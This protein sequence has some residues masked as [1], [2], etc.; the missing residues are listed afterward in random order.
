MLKRILLIIGVLLSGHT[1][2]QD[3]WTLAKGLTV[4]PPADLDLTFQVIED[5]DP[6]QKLLV[7]WQGEDLLYAFAIDKQP[8][9]LPT[10]T[11]FSGVKG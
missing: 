4:V 8:G 7:G 2:A 1:L 5:Y 6:N 11:Y 3:T 9:G 10:K